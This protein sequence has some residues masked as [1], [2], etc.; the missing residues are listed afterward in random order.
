VRE[1]VEQRLD[2]DDPTL[3]TSDGWQR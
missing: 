2:V 1:A 3:G